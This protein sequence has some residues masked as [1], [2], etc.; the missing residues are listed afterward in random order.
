ME[1]VGVGEGGEQ[2]RGVNPDCP[3]AANPF[4][5]CA[6]HCPVPPPPR[7]AAK[8]PPPPPGR[9]K[10]VMNGTAHRNG[11]ERV[12]A[13]ASPA[14]EEISEVTE[15]PEDVGERRA[16][17]RTPA[18][19]EEAGGGDQWRAVNPDC[20]NAVNPFH[21]CAEYC[22]VPAVPKSPARMPP[23]S[24]GHS[25]MNGRTHS[26]GELHPKPR[27]RDKGGGSGG[28]PLYVFRE[29]PLS[30]P[31]PT[32]LPRFYPTKISSLLVSPRERKKTNLSACCSA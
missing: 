13:A 10:A 16:G 2:L 6:A 21:R 20:P 31:S 23:P 9:G 29:F 3:N 26:D 30:V 12:V 14:S 24:L 17:A 11:G 19:D 8:S 1:G 15:D 27:R 5:R 32:V 22:P 25:A 4:H 18:R 28:L 7:V